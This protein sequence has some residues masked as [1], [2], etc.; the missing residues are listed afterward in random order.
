MSDL[1][2]DSRMRKRGL[3]DLMH[4][5][6]CAVCGNGTYEPG[7]ID[8]GVYYDYEGQVYLCLACVNEIADTAGLLTDTEAQFLCIQNKDFAEKNEKLVHDLKVANERL[9]HYDALFNSNFESHP[10]VISDLESEDKQEDGEPADE[11]VNDGEAEEPVINES[12]TSE[13]PANTSGIEQPNG[14]EL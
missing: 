1:N 10:D 4:P 7:Y 3:G 13:G 8:I 5:G 11:S 14:I 12:V 2:P 6:V 9:Q